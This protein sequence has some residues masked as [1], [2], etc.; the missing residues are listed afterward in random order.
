MNVLVNYMILC[1]IRY[2][3][4]FFSHFYFPWLEK[5]LLLVGKLVIGN[6][7]SLFIDAF[8]FEIENGF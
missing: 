8:S 4:F 1:V 5:C 7:Y 6:K 3:T 2:L